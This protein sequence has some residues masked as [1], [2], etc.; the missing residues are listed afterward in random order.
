MNP[1][2]G[3]LVRLQP[4][5]PPDPEQEAPENREKRRR[6]MRDLTALGYVPVPEASRRR[7][8]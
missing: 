4:E 7:N 8:R 5:S 6:H 3:H 1:D 2:D